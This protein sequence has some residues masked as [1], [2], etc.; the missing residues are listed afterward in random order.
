MKIIKTAK[1]KNKIKISKKEWTKIGKKGGWMKEASVP[2]VCEKCGWETEQ[3]TNMGTAGQANQC[4]QCGGRMVYKETEAWQT[5][6]KK[7]ELTKVAT[8]AVDHKLKMAVRQAVQETGLSYQKA[9]EFSQA[10][11]RGIENLNMPISQLTSMIEAAAQ[12]DQPAQQEQQTQQAADP[13][14]Q[15]AMDSHYGQGGVHEPLNDPRTNH[16]RQGM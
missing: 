4:Q 7:D 8:Q 3:P 9:I 6:N 12:P 15:A 11:L 13:N 10:L 5:A 14:A 1:G 16:P 2:S